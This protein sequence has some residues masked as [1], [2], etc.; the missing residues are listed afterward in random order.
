M[1]KATSAGAAVYTPFTLKLYDWW[2]L[3]VSNQYAWRCPTSANLLPHFVKH[4]GDSHLDIG[5]GTGYY[6]THLPENCQLAL[7]DL[8]HNSLQVAARRVGTER[9]NKSLAHDIYQPFPAE[10]QQQF[11]SVSLFYLLHCLPGTMT[12]KQVVIKHAAMALKPDGQ[13]SGATI[14]G[15]GV[16]HNALGR[17]LMAVYNKKGIFSNQLD[18]ENTLHE[19][20]S[21]CFTDV[22]INVVG[23][24]ALFRASSPRVA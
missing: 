5:V 9:V 12:D 19:A 20:L 4:T 23:T 15:K 16:S 21:T 3:S 11:D 14:L 8:N 22:E 10:W 13:L 6:L 24:V 18:C 2:V 17:K 7:A 1:K